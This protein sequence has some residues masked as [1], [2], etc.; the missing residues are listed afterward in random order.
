MCYCLLDLY[1]FVELWASNTMEVYNFRS[2]NEFGKRMLKFKF[3]WQQ[4]KCII[5]NIPELLVE[6]NQNN[7][8]TQH[9]QQGILIQGTWKSLMFNFEPEI[10]SQRAQAADF[11]IIHH[12]T[13]AE[14]VKVKAEKSELLNFSRSHE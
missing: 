5:A 6:H 8:L 2:E 14:R 7:T 3:A 1:Q 13:A 9:S 10:H 12:T 11:Q 4:T